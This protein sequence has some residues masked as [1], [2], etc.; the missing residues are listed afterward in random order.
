M[1]KTNDEKIIIQSISF[2]KHLPRVML[3]IIICM[4]MIFYFGLGL[5]LKS[6][7]GIFISMIFTAMFIIPIYFLMSVI[8]G[9]KITVT[10]KRIYGKTAWKTVSLPIDSISSVGLGTVGISVSTSSGLIKFLYIRNRMEIYS[11]I[12]DLLNNR[13]ESYNVKDNVSGFEE[14][15]ELKKLLDD[16]IITQEE[17]DK[18]KK[19]ILKL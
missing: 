7:L 12:I 4:F 5:Y 15:V 9:T 13:Q 18:K 10:D 1:R 16:G 14:L 6:W 17:F 11:S 8:A 2:I 19:E 3:M